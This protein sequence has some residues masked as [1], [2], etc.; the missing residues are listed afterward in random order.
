M[1]LVK[2]GTIRPGQKIRS[3]HNQKEYHVSEVGIMYP[4]MQPVEA[5]HAGQ[6][7]YIICDMKT[8][9]EAGIGET[10]FEPSQIDK[11][12]AFPGF[13]PNQPTVYS[14]LY[15]VDTGDYEQLLRALEKLMLNDPSVTMTKETS[16]ALG[17]GFKMGFL[18]MLHLEVSAPMCFTI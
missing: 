5:L 7:G 16:P 14:G 18:G 12:V 13:K 8:A 10:L 11:V 4:E 2:E 3:F 6:V 15:P 1:I 9:A 17:F